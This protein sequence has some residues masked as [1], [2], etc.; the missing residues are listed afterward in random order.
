M[1]LRLFSDPSVR[2]ATA[3]KHGRR[4]LHDV[5]RTTQHAIQRAAILVTACRRRTLHHIHLGFTV[6]TAQVFW[7]LATLCCAAGC[8][9]SKRQHSL[10]GPIESAQIQPGRPTDFPSGAAHVIAQVRC[11]REDRCNN[12]G[13]GKKYHTAEECLRRVNAEWRESLNLLECPRGIKEDGL[14]ECLR[15]IRTSQ[16]GD[17]LDTLE[18]WVACS[19]DR[20]CDGPPPPPRPHNPLFP[21]PVAPIR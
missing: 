9:R 21:K 4:R 7:A 15:A 18:R 20:I 2:A 16:C 19:E 10:V 13:E 6:K 17:V 3:C 8:G 11:V 5:P 12:V 14:A 1:E